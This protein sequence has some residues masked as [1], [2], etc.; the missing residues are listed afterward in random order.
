MVEVLHDGPYCPKPREPGVWC[1]RGSYWIEPQDDWRV[2]V[3]T[4][5]LHLLTQWREDNGTI[6]NNQ[7]RLADVKS[8]FRQ[9]D[10]RRCIYEIL[11]D[12]NFGAL[13]ARVDCWRARQAG[14]R[15]DGELA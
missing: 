10:I 6:R 12:R 8:Q 13:Q 15:T 14:T 4:D 5:D 3:W 1:Y 9:A 11:G 2:D 7:Y